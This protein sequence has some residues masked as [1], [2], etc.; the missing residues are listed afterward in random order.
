MP[1][2]NYF[3][4][5][6]SREECF[7]GPD[8]LS[9]AKKAERLSLGHTKWGW[10]W[11][12]F[13]TRL[14]LEQL[15]EKKNETSFLWKE[16]QSLRRT[17]ALPKGHKDDRRS[18]FSQRFHLAY[19]WYF[20][21]STTFLRTDRR[22]YT[23]KQIIRK[24]WEHI[25]EDKGRGVCIQ[26]ERGLTWTDDHPAAS[27]LLLHPRSPAAGA[28]LPSP[29]LPAVPE[30]LK[31]LHLFGFKIRRWA[32]LGQNHCTTEPS[33][34]SSAQEGLVAEALLALFPVDLGYTPK[35]KKIKMS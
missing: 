31:E 25:P 2:N 10:G 18:I 35:Q 16:T 21:V 15:F 9:T 7:K 33:V 29:G 13:I 32:Q 12:G 6:L 23:Y 11:G 26:A 3:I 27:L 14:L 5:F 22:A 1:V 24:I 8:G 28:L 4:V 20:D 17:G 30:G 19:F 34:F